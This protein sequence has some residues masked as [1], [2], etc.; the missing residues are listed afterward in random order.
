MWVLIVVASLGTTDRGVAVYSVPGFTNETTCRAAQP[1][2]RRGR[3]AG[4]R[5][6]MR[7]G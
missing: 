6:K 5:Q 2:S 7:K 1:Q 3:K 4:F